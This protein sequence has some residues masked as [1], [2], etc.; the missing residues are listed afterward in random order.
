MSDVRFPLEWSPD[1]ACTAELF[2]QYAEVYKE[3]VEVLL[4]GLQTRGLLHDYQPLPVLFLF[5]HYIELQL[6][7]LIAYNDGTFEN[8][9][10][11][12]VLLDKL[13]GLDPAVH[14]PYC[15]DMI[16][17]LQ[18]LDA[19]SDGFRYPLSKDMKRFFQKTGDEEFYMMITTLSS[20]SKLITATIAELENVE[21]YYDYLKDNPN[22]FSEAS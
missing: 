6:K 7:G 9:H 3:A 22:D 1:W 8:F 17:R 2:L 21:G 5:R 10:D 14:L 16:P 4:N 19:R 18:K 11:L 13:K 15:S 20:M 12:A